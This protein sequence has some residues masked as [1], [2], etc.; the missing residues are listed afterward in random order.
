M[1]RPDAW[2]AQQHKLTAA[3]LALGRPAGQGRGDMLAFALTLEVTAAPRLACSVWKGGQHRTPALH[4]RRPQNIASRRS[5]CT[6][7]A[8]P[9]VGPW[10]RQPLRQ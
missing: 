9:V 1:L 3:L 8:L 10:A 6:L 4:P 7:T 5:C 2:Q